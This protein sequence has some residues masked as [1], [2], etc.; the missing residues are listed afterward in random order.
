MNMNDYYLAPN[1]NE[2]VKKVCTAAFPKYKGKKCKIE[3]RKGT[4]NLRSYWDGG[5]RSYYAIVR[6][7][8]NKIG[9]VPT[10]HPVYDRQIKDVDNFTIPSGFCIVENRIFCGRDMGLIIHVNEDESIK[11]FDNPPDE[12]SLNKRIVLYATKSLKSSYGGI[13]NFRFYEAKQSTGINLNDWNIAKQ[14]LIN[15]KLLNKA[16]AITNLGRNAIGT[17]FS[18]PT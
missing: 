11:L 17:G 14:E 1:D 2:Q 5:S 18:W 7:S 16:G 12:L 9:N 15:D 3:Y 4:I 6:L 8:D 13:K 10:C